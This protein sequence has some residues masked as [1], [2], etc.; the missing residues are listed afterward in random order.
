MHAQTAKALAGE[1]RDRIQALGYLRHKLIIQVLHT[2]A[3]QCAPTWLPCGFTRVWSTATTTVTNCWHTL[4]V[5]VCQDTGQAMRVASRCLWDPA[6]DGS[7]WHHLRT[8]TL[9]CVCQVFGLYLE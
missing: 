3:M 5:T 6:N 9:T 1:L 4:Q 7:A 2:Q 8:D